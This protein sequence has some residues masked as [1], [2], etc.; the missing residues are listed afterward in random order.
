MKR[1]PKKFRNVWQWQ[2]FQS[3]LQML[4]FGTVLLAALLGIVASTDPQKDEKRLKSDTPTKEDRSSQI[5]E[6]INTQTQRRK[7]AL[8]F[9]K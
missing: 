9:Q 2:N 3:F 1:Y 5:L 7:Y 8:R 6:Y 4:I